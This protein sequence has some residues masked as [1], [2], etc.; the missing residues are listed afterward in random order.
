MKYAVCVKKNL[1]ERLCSGGRIWV[2]WNADDYV[3]KGE[4]ITTTDK[5]KAQE[6]VKNFWEHVVEVSN[7]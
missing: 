2:G 5:A 6:L 1:Q 3:T 7:D 4:R